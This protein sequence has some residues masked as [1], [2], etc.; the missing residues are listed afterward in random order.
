MNDRAPKEFIVGGD[1]LHLQIVLVIRCSQRL[2][3]RML[4]RTDIHE[5][6]VDNRLRPRCAT[7]DRVLADL[8]RLAKFWLELI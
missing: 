4:Q 1:L 3:E 5:A 6:I 7:R 8:Y 2:E